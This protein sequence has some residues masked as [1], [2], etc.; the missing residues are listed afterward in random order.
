MTFKDALRTKEF[1]VTAQVNLAQTSDAE[2]LCQQGEILSPAV[3]AV[4]LTDTTQVHMSGLAAAA[5]LL[6]Q[7]IDPIIHMNCRDRNRIALRKDFL[8]AA[9]LG[10]SSVM[11]KR[12]KNIRNSKKLG[13]RNV[14]DTPALKFME[15]IKSL[16]HSVIPFLMI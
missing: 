3:D 16:K 2:S 15:Y 13:V 4:Q 12:G 11:V 7:G 5:I 6:Q 1:V 9:A 8:G 10:V 14:F